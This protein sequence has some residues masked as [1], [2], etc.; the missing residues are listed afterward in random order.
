MAVTVTERV[1]FSGA[2]FHLIDFANPRLPTLAWHET[3]VTGEILE[4]RDTETLYGIWV[5]SMTRRYPTR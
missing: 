2:T 5:S 1:I 4:D 3:T